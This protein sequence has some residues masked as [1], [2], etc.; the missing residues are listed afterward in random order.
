MRLAAIASTAVVLLSTACTDSVSPPP[1]E[2]DAPAL[3]IR[4]DV[5]VRDKGC[6]QLDYTNDGRATLR[7]RARV[8]L[9]FSLP[10]LETARASKE[11]GRRFLRIA[12]AEFISDAVGGRVVI[13]C[14]VPAS[15]TDA[16][17]RTAAARRIAPLAAQRLEVATELDV[18]DASTLHI[19]AANALEKLIQQQSGSV[20]LSLPA[21]SPSKPQNSLLPQKASMQ[22]DLFDAQTLPV[23]NVTAT[24]SS[25]I[26]NSSQ[27][28]WALYHL[29][30][31]SLDGA[32]FVESYPPGFCATQSEMW[33]ALNE[34][35]EDLEEQRTA[36]AAAITSIAGTSANLMC[37][38]R[39][40]TK[41]TCVD[42]FIS[43]ATVFVTGFGDNRGFNA[44]APYGASRI[45]LYLD[46]DSLKGYYYLTASTAYVPLPSSGWP[47]GF[48]H[49]E[50]PYPHQ[51]K[52]FTLTR[53]A[54]GQVRLHV[55]AFNGFCS[56]ATRETC[57]TIDADITFTREAS[58]QWTT[59]TSSID[60]DN[61]PSLGVYFQ[62]PDGSF[63]KKYED[64]EGHWSA[65]FG[66]QRMI[67][68]LRQKME[69]T[70]GT[71]QL[72]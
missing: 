59:N 15:Y 11:S 54:N 61:Y 51:S 23:W 62:Q 44:N 21:I 5:A 41:R 7:Q 48:F 30:R 65:L 46:L 12:T 24:Y 8:D 47:S 17:L 31:W 40:D 49:T 26:M 58:G 67:N 64:A 36:M 3:D 66:I 34:E 45:Q 42:F 39:A 32:G 69:N 72:E 28:Y 25:I 18:R 38:P 53:L 13:A 9:P 19:T 71:C 10:K 2:I 27:I 43:S 70:L 37:V 14:L 16:M 52:D 57:P 4:A 29:S 22:G 60:R 55:E 68:K 20:R 1:A 50:A 33:V 56:F 35:L 6:T 63:E